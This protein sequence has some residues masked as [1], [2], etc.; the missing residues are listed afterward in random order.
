MLSVF[1][2]PDRLLSSMVAVV[3]PFRKLCHKTKP[4]ENIKERE[5][6]GRRSNMSASAVTHACLS[7]VHGKEFPYNS[8]SSDVQRSLASTCECTQ[9]D[10]LKPAVHGLQNVERV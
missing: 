8:P 6:M 9:N 10:K 2:T 7:M 4:H 5:L 1:L 3:P